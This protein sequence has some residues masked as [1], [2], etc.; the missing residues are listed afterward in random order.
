MLVNSNV[1]LE[2]SKIKRIFNKL[3]FDSSM[4][5]N[6]VKNNK[7]ELIKKSSSVKGFEYEVYTYNG[8]IN[9]LVN[10][11]LEEI[12][13]YER[14]VK[15]SKD[16]KAFWD[17]YKKYCPLLTPTPVNAVDNQSLIANS[18]TKKLLLGGK[19]KKRFFNDYEN[20]LKGSKVSTQDFKKGPSLNQMISFISSVGDY[21]D[22]INSEMKKAQDEFNLRN[23]QNL[24]NL[25]SLS[26][27]DRQMYS[28]INEIMLW[29]GAHF[30]E[31][32]KV[33]SDCMIDACKEFYKILQDLKSHSSSKEST[34][35]D[36]I[37][38]NYFLI[39][40]NR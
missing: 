2:S 26:V 37:L 35:L 36:N 19:S 16:F 25:A 17:K 15:E 4:Y 39:I 21:I 20:S 23:R 30:K 22:D 3:T 33:I 38:D 1:V 9:N 6:Y 24:V 13:E 18:I 34:I 8:K 27:W 28:A 12:K 7:S 5:S 10:K 32:I 40:Q 11:A 29:F 31:R 14:Y